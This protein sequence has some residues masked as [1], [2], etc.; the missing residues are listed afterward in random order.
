MNIYNKI[1]KIYRHAP[2]FKNKN[3]IEY[4]HKN[5]IHITH[6]SNRRIFMEV[7]SNRINRDMHLVGRTEKISKILHGNKLM[8]NEIIYDIL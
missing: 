8:D 7:N 5:S 3:K 6:V 4:A 1:N 2:P